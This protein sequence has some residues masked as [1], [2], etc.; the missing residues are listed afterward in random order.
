[1]AAGWPPDTRRAGSTAR[2]PAELVAVPPGRPWRPGLPFAQARARAR[3]VAGPARA[4]QPVWA[5]ARE[6]AL[7][8][9]QPEIRARWLGDTIPDALSTT[10]FGRSTGRYPNPTLYS[11]RLGQDDHLAST[12]RTP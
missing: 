11:P 5:P 8:N 2:R 6:P 10:I 4:C 9:R 1:S 12:R 7:E 3:P